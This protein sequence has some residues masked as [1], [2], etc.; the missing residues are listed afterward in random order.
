MTTI[1][2]IKVAITTVEA[3]AGLIF[4]GVSLWS[5]SGIWT[6][7]KGTPDCEGWAML[8]AYIFAPTGI[9]IITASIF[10]AKTRSWFSQVAL[11]LGLG[12]LLWWELYA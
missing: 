10:L 4:L 12:W 7:P 11:V 5:I 1:G 6:C 3:I 2:K 9:L 8:G